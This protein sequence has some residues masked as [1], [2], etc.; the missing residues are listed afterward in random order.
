MFCGEGL[1]IFDWLGVHRNRDF[2]LC[3]CFIRGHKELDKGFVSGANWCA[4]SAELGVS[5]R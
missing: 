3:L 5:G 1:V 2:L 4:G